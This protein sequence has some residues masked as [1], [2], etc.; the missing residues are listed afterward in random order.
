MYHSSLKYLITVGIIKANCVDED[1][2]TQAV[3]RLRRDERV[4]CEPVP[5]G[6]AVYLASLYAAEEG[7]AR[8]LLTLAEGG[9][10]PTDIDIERAIAWVEQANRLHLAA[11]QQE[12]IRQALQQKLLVITGGP[13]TGKTTILRCILQILD[14]KHRRMLLCSPT[15]RAAKRMSEATGRE[16]K[17]IHRLLE[18]S[19]KDGRFKRDH[20]RRR[21]AVLVLRKVGNPP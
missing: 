9:A 18:F 17:T 11:Q 13:G 15:G 20:H 10:P 4:I 5:Q 3:D 21:L 2:V 7:V 6:M 14:K 1:L 8:R 16:A 12:A 19:P